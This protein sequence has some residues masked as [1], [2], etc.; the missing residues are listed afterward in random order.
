[1]DETEALALELSDQIGPKLA[2]GCHDAILTQMQ[3]T[4]EWDWAVDDFLQDALIDG[5]RVAP[6]LLT[7]VEKHI[8]DGYFHPDLEERT[9]GW[10][11]Q[12]KEKQAVTFQK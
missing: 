8:I 12:L 6:E 4:G 3:C 7:K 10:I 2:P 9:M 1:M 5:I 11:K